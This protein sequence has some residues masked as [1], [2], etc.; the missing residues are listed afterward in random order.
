MADA[1]GNFDAE[2]AGLVGPSIE[3]EHERGMRTVEDAR[4]LGAGHSHRRMLREAKVQRDWR[5]RPPQRRRHRHLDHLLLGS[6][7]MWLGRRR[8]RGGNAVR[9]AARRRALPHT[10]KVELRADIVGGRRARSIGRLEGEGLRVA[11]DEAAVEDAGKR[12]RRLERDVKRHVRLPRVESNREAE[13]VIPFAISFTANPPHSS[14]V[15][16]PPA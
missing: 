8:D 12:A 4:M 1:D 13:A 3:L 11:R 2:R 10:A 5:V 9:R 6:G 15:A 16:P 14:F 7:V